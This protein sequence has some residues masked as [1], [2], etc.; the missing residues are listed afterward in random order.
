M[1][2]AAIQTLAGVSNQTS[3]NGAK[4][5]SLN[6]DTVSVPFSIV[7]MARG[8]TTL[9]PVQESTVGSTTD[10]SIMAIFNATTLEELVQELGEM[11]DSELSALELFKMP[12]LENLLDYSNSNLSN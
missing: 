12:E 9:T 1:N 10:D 3:P 7:I 5:G 2:I 6:G 4:V 8:A 11:K